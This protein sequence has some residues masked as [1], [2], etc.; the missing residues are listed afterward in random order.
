M[1]GKSQQ[2]DMQQAAVQQGEINKEAVTQ[3]TYANR[4]T[5]YTP[6]G[7]VSW[8]PETF[9]DPGTGD[10]VTRWSQTTALTPALQDILNKQVAIQ[11]GRA[12]IAGALTGR[13]GSEFG[14]PMDWSGLS[15]MGEVPISQFTMPEGDVGDPYATRQ[16]AEDAVFNQAMSR[17]DPRFASERQA[18][19]IRLRN[20][21]LRPGDE[22]WQSQM[23]ALGQTQNDARNQAL[24]SASGAGRAESAQMFGQQL[25]RNQNNFNQALSA[26]QQNFGQAMQGSAYA[27]QLRQQQLTEAMQRRGFSLNE[28]NALLSGQQVGMPQMPNF[29]QAQAAQPAPIYQG[30]ADQ[31]SI[32]AANNPWNAILDAGSSL[33][34]AAI[35]R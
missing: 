6:W 17:L 25:G 35:L 26:N 28:I 24:W 5:Q 11:G 18:T 2:P 30:A 19:E 8:T 20:Q 12:D 3:Q 32:N 7:A 29:S 33:G 31:A 23:E 21:G 9:T 1:G 10:E 27:N 4:P 15:P 34:A 16:A 14:N 22:L 13:M